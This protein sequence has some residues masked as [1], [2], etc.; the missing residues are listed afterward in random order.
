MPV[1]I[2][3][4][5]C[6]IKKVKPYN[7][8]I[9]LCLFVGERAEVNTWKCTRWSSRKTFPLRLFREGRKR[10][11][12]WSVRAVR[13]SAKWNPQIS[14]VCM[15]ANHGFVVC[16][17]ALTAFRSVWSRNPWKIVSSCS[18]NDQ[19][20][21]CHPSDPLNVLNKHMQYFSGNH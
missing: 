14:G 7:N 18:C 15:C 1:E 4:I 20:T 8:P 9:K 11:S 13:L 5:T 2:W 12:D 19:S 3:Y 16:V 17:C 10:E 6:N 21:R